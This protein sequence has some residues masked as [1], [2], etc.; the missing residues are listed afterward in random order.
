MGPGLHNARLS[1]SSVS[2]YNVGIRTLVSGYRDAMVKVAPRALCNS[3]P[4]YPIHPL[5]YTSKSGTVN[6]EPLGLILGLSV[7]QMPSYI[8]SYMASYITSY[9]TKP[10]C[11]STRTV[12]R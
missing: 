7:A 1:P 10:G 3:G 9:I 8:T 2:G 11:G 12:N 6:R 5:G 4:T